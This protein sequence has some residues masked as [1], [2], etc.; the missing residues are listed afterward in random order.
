MARRG[1]ILAALLGGATIAAA[2]AIATS[3]PSNYHEALNEDQY[4]KLPEIKSPMVTVVAN[5]DRVRA[6]A[7]KVAGNHGD[8]NFVVISVGVYDDHF[9]DHD[10]DPDLSKSLGAV[11]AVDAKGVYFSQWGDS[12]LPGTDQKILDDI[13]YAVAVALGAR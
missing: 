8:V 2:Y 7:E 4:Q 10:K 5:D 1:K 12:K 3:K 6:I 13:V 11:F 9:R